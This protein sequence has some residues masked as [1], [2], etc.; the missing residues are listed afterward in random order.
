[1]LKY[2]T[3]YYLYKESKT[4]PGYFSIRVYISYAGKRPRIYTGVHVNQIHWDEKSQR[5]VEK[6][7]EANSEIN[8]MENIIRDIFRTYDYQHQR[9]PSPEE[10][11]ESFNKLYKKQLPDPEVLA[12]DLQ[13]SYVHEKFTEFMSEIGDREQWSDAVYNRYT[14]LQN[15]FKFY[16]ETLV[17][18]TLEESDLVGLIK[19]FQKAPKTML[20]NGKIKIGDPHKNT[21]LSRTLKD[22]RTFL[23]WA[24]KQG[25]YPGDLFETFKPKLKGIGTDLNELVYLNWDELMQF[26]NYE[27]TE[28]QKHLEHVRDV[29][30][31][32]CFS[33]LRFSDVKKLKKSHIRDTY[34]LTTTKKTVDTLRIDLN[35]FTEE[36][37]A[38]YEGEDLGGDKALPVISEQNTNDH[39]KTIGHL[40]R[41]DSPITNVY[42]IGNTRHE[43]TLPKYALMTTHIGRRTFVVNAIYLK[44]PETVIMKWTGHKD[45]QSMKPYIAVVDELKVEQMNKF[46]LKKRK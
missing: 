29:V 22:V 6:H 20:R 35:D 5:S 16:N 23:R 1:M 46:N 21:T 34:F 18:E 28:D 37:L 8:E 10:L 4:Q 25:F 41:F 19:Y 15:H 44:I 11:K 42:F 27:F 14:K 12:R 13:K 26:Y 2:K 38:K 36:I 40:L 17:L 7:S 9:F 24:N 30:A 39:L 43:E 32:C 33:S 31:F 3:N 45:Y